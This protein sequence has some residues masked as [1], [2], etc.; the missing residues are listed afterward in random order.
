LQAAFQTVSRG[1]GHQ[2]HNGLQPDV[3]KSAMQFVSSAE[4]AI[5]T[6]YA[7]CDAELISGIEPRGRFIREGLRARLAHDCFDLIGPIASSPKNCQSLNR[8]L[9]DHPIA[10]PSGTLEETP[11]SALLK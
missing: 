11:W 7:R 9:V 1:K 8:W 6:S 5:G 2:K 3:V 4:A 10:S